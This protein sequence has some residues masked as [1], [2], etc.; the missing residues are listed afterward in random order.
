MGRKKKNVSV[1]MCEWRTRTCNHHAERAQCVVQVV[2]VFT[3]RIQSN[4]VPLKVADDQIVNP[5]NAASIHGSTAVIA[6]TLAG[7]RVDVVAI[8]EDDVVGED[9]LRT[10]VLFWPQEV[11]V[12]RV[13]GCRNA[14]QVCRDT[15]WYHNWV[16]GPP[17]SCRYN[18]SV[19]V[20]K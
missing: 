2:A 14:R 3:A 20:S 4:I 13:V 17:L 9:R 11:P 19:T 12:Y 7:R 10:G 15:G 6:W 18:Q 16:V 8:I 1:R 5:A